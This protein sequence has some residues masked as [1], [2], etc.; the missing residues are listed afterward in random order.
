MSSAHVNKPRCLNLWAQVKTFIHWN[1]WKWAVNSERHKNGIFPV[2]KSKFQCYLFNQIMNRKAIPEYA[3]ETNIKV[4]YKIIK[5]RSA[6]GSCFCFCFCL[7]VCIPVW[8]AG[9][10]KPK[11]RRQL[12]GF[13]FFFNRTE[14]QK[15]SIS[16]NETDWVSEA[17]KEFHIESIFI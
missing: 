11:I 12:F 9:E 10:S 16:R 17:R 5:I 14:N 13:F 8:N 6:A 15:S 2:P 7:C 1:H 4:I 3:N